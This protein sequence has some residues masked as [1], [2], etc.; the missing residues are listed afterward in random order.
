MNLSKWNSFLYE[1]V[2]ET[3]TKKDEYSVPDIVVPRG[4]GIEEKVLSELSDRFELKRK[5]GEGKYGVVY[6]LESKSSEAGPDDKFN[7]VK[8]IFGA[9][10]GAVAREINN[11]QF[12][13]DN[14]QNLGVRRKYF[15]RVY[16]TK[17]GTY[18]SA[19]SEMNPNPPNFEFGYVRMEVL[20]P[21]D[22]RVK[23]DLLAT[24]GVTL[25]PGGP[26]DFK[27]VDFT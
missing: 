27:K 23:T 6:L 16:E 5:L 15:P 13:K 20:E 1:E 17:Q 25:G 9:D 10:S 2:D 21:I 12:V 8:I 4:M 11:Y 14:Y 22:P 18:A 3:P 24:G 19:P 26:Y 7:A